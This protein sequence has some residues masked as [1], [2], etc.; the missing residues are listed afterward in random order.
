MMEREEPDLVLTDLR[1]PRMDGLEL[2]AQLRRRHPLVPVILMTSRGSEDIAVQS[3]RRGASSYVPKRALAQDLLRT[4]HSLLELVGAT[5]SRS[6]VLRTIVKSR[7]VYLLDND[8]DLLSDVVG[9]IEAHLKQIEFGDETECIRVS[10]ALTEALSNALYHG[11]LE[12]DSDLR[13]KDFEAYLSLA[14]E[15][16]GAEPYRSRKIRLQAEISREEVSFKVT[17]QGRGF[18]P[19]TLPDVDTPPSMEKVTGRGILLMRTLMD[20]VEFAADGNQVKM[21]RRA[22]GKRKKKP[23]SNKVRKA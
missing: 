19:A 15:R 9:D 10:V 6:R 17:D 13:E 7:T 21:V 23:S 16:A 22:R 4:I 18:D 20:T 8:Y 2:V 12:M 1:M 3:L 14:R 5:R 11:N